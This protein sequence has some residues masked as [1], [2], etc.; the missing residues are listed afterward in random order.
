MQSDKN[1]ST[2]ASRNHGRSDSPKPP[3]GDPATFTNDTPTPHFQRVAK[4]AFDIFAATLGLCV[5]SPMFLLVSIAIKLDSR[6]PIFSPQVRHGYDNQKIP[7]LRF[8]STTME[9]MDG[10]IQTARKR[11]SATRVGRVLRRT[12]VDQLP[13]LINV[14]R[15][16]MSIVGP[17]PYRIF[18]GKIL[19]E[20]IPRN[21]SRHRATPGIT[22][23]AQVNGYWSENDSFKAMQRRIEHDLYYIDNWSFVLDMK[24]ILMTLVSK[25][26]YGQT[27]DRRSG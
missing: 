20:Q 21:L 11:S 10:F 8:R 16:D 9:N 15:G 5:F 2:V 13:Q 12:G 7:V 25:K 4:R 6:G 26:A 18:P 22:G 19:E 17:R 3:E 23:W 14:L 1:K 24:I 27:G